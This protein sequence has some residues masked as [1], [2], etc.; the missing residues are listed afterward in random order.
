[1]ETYCSHLGRKLTTIVEVEDGIWTSQITNLTLKEYIQAHTLYSS[2]HHKNNCKNCE[3]MIKAAQIIQQNGLCSLSMVF[4]AAFP[5]S[6]Y[7][8]KQAHCRLLQMPLAAIRVGEPSSGF[9]EIHI[10]EYI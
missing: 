3:S 5:Q 6:S 2:L 10:T 4:K 9:S 1:M 7:V 8:V